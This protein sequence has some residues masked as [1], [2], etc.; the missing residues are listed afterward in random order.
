MSV[1]YEFEY[2][3]RDGRLVCIKPNESYI[4][5]SKTNEH[6]WQVRKD[7]HSRP[8]Y[9]P[10]Q[11][12]KE[13]PS[14][15]RDSSGLDKLD[16]TE[17]EADSKP[18]DM[19]NVTPDR[20]TTAVRCVSNQDAPRETY[21]FSTFGF[22]EDI[23]DVK[24]CEILKEG[25][26]T[27]SSAHTLDNIKTHNSTE[28]FS[29]GLELY[30]KPHQVR[31]GPSQSKSLPQ[32]ENVQQ[33]QTILDDEDIS[34]PLPPDLPI[35]DTIPELNSTEFHT[36]ISELPDPVHSNDTSAFQQQSLNQAAEETSSTD[37]PPSEQ[38]RS[39]LLF[40]CITLNLVFKM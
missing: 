5:I 20:A 34:F 2:T 16:S 12:M 14:C 25:K 1:Q 37:A 10:A 39:F 30:A 24:Y 36:I 33:P 4:L 19:A 6:W 22:C 29:F 17:C 28:D 23:P 27:K 40:L 31:N 15:T 9:V 32:D 11:Y 38:V 8:F 26:T 35:Y 3:A 18:V 7:Q 21:R 13:F